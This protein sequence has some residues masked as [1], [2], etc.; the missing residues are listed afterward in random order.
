MAAFESSPSASKSS[1]FSR[2]NLDEAIFLFISSGVGVILNG[3]VIACVAA[4]RSL[5]RMTSAFLVHAC[6]LD[7][8]KCLYCIPFANSLLQDIP[9][10]YCSALGGSYVV[11][12]TASGFNIVAMVCCEAYTFSERN[13]GGEARGSLCCVFFG[14]LMVYVGSVIIH[15]GPT[16]I[17]GDFNYNDLIGNCIFVYG[18]VKSYV[19]HAMWII[20]MTIVMI[21]AVYYL[22]YFHRHVQAN[23]THRLASLVRASV[24]VSRGDTNDNR[25]IARLVRNSLSRVRVLF[26]ITGL[27]IFCWYPLYLLTLFDPK[28]QESTKVYKLLTFIAWSNSSLNPLVLTLFDKNID[29]LGRIFCVCT[30]CC[31]VPPDNDDTSQVLTSADLRTAPTTRR[32]RSRTGSRSARQTGLSQDLVY[33]RVG[34]RLCHEGDANPYSANCN[35]RTEGNGRLMRAASLVE[36]DAFFE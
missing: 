1:Q 18:T 23:S 11:I 21:G 26:L 28:F 32:S 34:C 2:E 5:R 7:L 13:L 3:I 20:I 25:H 14:V 17:G 4:I 27:F 36:M 31:P 30:F 12:V 24:A 35:G 15:L 33:Q 6:I 19:V 9:P 8:V 22:V 16:I 29:V 10:S